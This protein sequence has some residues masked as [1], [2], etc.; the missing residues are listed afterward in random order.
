[1][2]LEFTCCA[3]C[4]MSIKGIQEKDW[5]IYANFRRYLKII[6][7]PN[8]DPSLAM[9]P[10]QYVCKRCH[11]DIQKDNKELYLPSELSDHI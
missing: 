10:R 7:S 5:F 1:M 8:D 9:L 4:G 6:E 2:D 3:Y 11:E